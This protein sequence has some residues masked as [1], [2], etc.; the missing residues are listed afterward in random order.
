MVMVS[1]V[2]LSEGS[3]FTHIAAML[4][5]SVHQKSQIYDSGLTHMIMY[6]PGLCF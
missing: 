2:V 5:S 3:A 1:N 6:R 4:C